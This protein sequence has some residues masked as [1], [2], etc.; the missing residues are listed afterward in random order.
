MKSTSGIDKAV[1]EIV[2]MGI[3]DLGNETNKIT[4]HTVQAAFEKETEE[5]LKKIK[6]QYPDITI[7]KTFTLGGVIA[8]HTGPGTICLIFTKDF[9]Y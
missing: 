2:E 4:I 6:E 3:A 5:Y 1:D 9:E 8:A 7:G